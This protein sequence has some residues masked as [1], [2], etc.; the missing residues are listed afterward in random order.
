M[1]LLSICIELVLQNAKLCILQCKFCREGINC[2]KDRLKR[3]K[4]CVRV[5]LLVKL[6][7]KKRKAMK[8]RQGFL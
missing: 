7:W 8:K 6:Q 1:I 4:E 2:G 5:K 3:E